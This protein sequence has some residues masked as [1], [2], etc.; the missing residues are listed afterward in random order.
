MSHVYIEGEISISYDKL[1]SKKDF[2]DLSLVYQGEVREYVYGVKTKSYKTSSLINRGFMMDKK[3]CEYRII[4][5][6][7]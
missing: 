3:I 1:V 6:S 2:N 5:I 4:K 7:Y